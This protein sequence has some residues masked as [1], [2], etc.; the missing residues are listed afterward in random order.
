[1]LYDEEASRQDSFLLC[2]WLCPSALI[3]LYSEQVKYA[4]EGY[5]ASDVWQE[6]VCEQD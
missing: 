5:L 1:M 3:R 2:F 4:A 6:L